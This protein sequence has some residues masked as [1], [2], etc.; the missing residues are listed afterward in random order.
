M[1]LKIRKGQKEIWNEG[2]RKLGEVSDRE[3]EASTGAYI[4]MGL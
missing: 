2:G 4:S 3:I 1:A